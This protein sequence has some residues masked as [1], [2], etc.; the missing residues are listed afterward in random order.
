MKEKL[1]QFITRHLSDIMNNFWTPI[2]HSWHLFG[3][4][5]DYLAI[6]KKPTG[7]EYGNNGAK[8]K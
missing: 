4:S 7:C 8:A 5:G 2:G 3:D 1:K 6:D